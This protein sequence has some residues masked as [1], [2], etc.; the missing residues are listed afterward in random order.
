MITARTA[1]P[2][3]AD[4]LL[5]RI[6]AFY[7]IEEI[8]Y[9]EEDVRDGLAKLLYTTDLGRAVLFEQEGR[10][11]GY[12]IVTWGYDLEYGGRDAY[13][14]DLYLDPDARGAGLGRAALAEIERVSR[15]DGVKQLHLMVRPEN[16]KALR[17]YVRAGFTRPP[18]LFFTKAL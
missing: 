13:L 2:R 7:A 12:A 9:A 11:V 18:R 15:E 3:D 17:L 10:V 16:H 5:P 14:T 8:P 4:E 6:A 1:T